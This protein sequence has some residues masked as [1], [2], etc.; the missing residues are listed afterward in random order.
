VG[1][2]NVQRR[3]EMFGARDSQLVATREADVFRVTLTLPAVAGD[4]LVEARNG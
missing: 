3:L 1:L 4:G 2:A